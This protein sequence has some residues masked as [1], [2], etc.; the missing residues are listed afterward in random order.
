MKKWCAVLLLAFVS[1]HSFAQTTDAVTG[2]QNQPVYND[3]V[4]SPYLFRDWSDGVIRFTSGRVATQ[5]KIKFDCIKNIILL[6]FNGSSF[7]TESKVK[8]FV[9]YTKNGKERDSMV[10]RKGFPPVEISNAET[11]FE[12]VAD[13]KNPLLCLH[14]KHITEEQ[15]IA[16]SVIYRRLRDED[17][18]YLL[19]DGKM[20]LLPA[21][22]MLIPDKFPDHTE[23]IK[24]F[25]NEHNLK[26]R[27][28]ED[29]KKLALY[30]N[31]L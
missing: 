29:F 24:K 3:V 13:G 12:V 30:Y 5:F 2:S 4:G 10:F 7:A 27:E 17:M 6:Q 26:F 11:Y 9:I 21:D 28:R 16:S 1:G 25:V 8:E 19:K 18:Y 23:N 20:I 31:S 15:Q 22:R 14:A